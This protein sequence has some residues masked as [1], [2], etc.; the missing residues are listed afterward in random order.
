MV[1]W[2]LMIVLCSAAAVIVSIPLIRRYDEHVA[3]SQDA[4]IYQ[5][6][7]KEVD[8]DLAAGNIHANEAERISTEIKRRI[9][10]AQSA[11][12][13]TNP[14][15][16]RLKL[17]SLA[18]MSAI[19]ILGGVGLY[20]LF[21]SPDVAG[22]RSGKPIAAQT[23][24]PDPAQQLDDVIAKVTS[25]LKTNP[26]DAETWRMLGWAQF[27]RQHFA[28]SSEAYAKALTIDPNNVD[29]KSAYAEALVQ[30]AE[31][32]VTP[33]AAALFTEV[34][35]KDPKDF[36]SRFYDAMAHEQSGDQ[37]GALDR[38]MAL[39]AESPADAGW[40]GEA[41]KH[42]ATLGAAL[43]R[44]VSAVIKAPQTVA[45]PPPTDAQKLAVQALPPA[46]QLAMIKGMVG[47]LSDKLAANPQDV[48]G[49]MMLMRSHLAL[50]DQPAAKDALAK[51]LAI[52]AND[53]AN[54]AKILANATTLGL[55]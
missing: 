10:A 45:V 3:A 44:D 36:R 11:S 47:K 12:N 46:D 14:L 15:S 17:A 1:F 27:N 25:Q 23:P 2:L 40:R 35:T 9:A 22:I 48:E 50:Q 13:K 7:L 54:K 42:I 16:P 30:I 21:G 19:V 53:P 4:A 38:W 33:K 28:E 31:G 55:N 5:D 37:A 41:T 6:Q 20:G 43:G 34:L 51:A 52:F 18:A 32:I 8:R 29:Y 49:W 24:N 39:L 26:N